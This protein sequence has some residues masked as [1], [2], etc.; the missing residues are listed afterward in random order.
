MSTIYTYQ[1]LLAVGERE[2]DKMNFIRKAIS[3]HQAKNDYTT[4]VSAR[5]YMAK[6]NPGILNFSKMIYTITGA[7]VKDPT[8]DGYKICSADFPFLVNQRNQYLLSNGASFGKPET[9]KKLGDDFDTVLQDAGESAMVDKVSFLFWNYDH[10]EYFKY[11]EFVPLYDEETGALKAGIRFW[12]IAS[13]KP[14]RATLYELDGYT[15]YIWES[16][17][18]AYGN[19]LHEKRG[20]KE[21][22]IKNPAD[23]MEIVEFENYPTFPI[24]PLWANKQKQSEIIG[25]KEKIDCYD[26]IV[27]GFANT[28]EEASYIYWSIENAGGMTQTDLVKFIEQ[29]KTIHAAA[30]DESGSKATA[31]SI[32]APFSGR[33]AIL[34]RLKE[35][36]YRDFGGFDPR[37]IVSG[38]TVTAQI[39]AAQKPLDQMADAFE[40]CVIKSIKNILDIIGIDD[41]PT[42]TRSMMINT[43]EEVTSLL[44]AA[45]YLPEDYVTKKLLILFGDGDIVD[46]IIAQKDDEADE[47]F[48]DGEEGTSDD[49][50]AALESYG[51]DVSAML[52]ELLKEVQ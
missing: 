52:E 37:S 35:D 3:N 7:K 14:F 25:M 15:D 24:V 26:L 18:A 45:Q 34:S 30:V 12:Q 42:F 9:K 39:K 1:D 49:G 17:S 29:M 41:N 8:G 23:G 13:D 20:Y 33:E 11:I 2:A 22:V 51:A 21:R 27:S 28:I 31:N 32:E 50:A 40:Y 19:V 10:M 4:A 44:Q 43:T 5:E 6:R 47:R 48:E 36:I 38:A 46:E 16:E